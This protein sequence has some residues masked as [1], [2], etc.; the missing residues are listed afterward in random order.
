MRRFSSA[1]MLIAAS[2][3]SVSTV[4]LAQATNDVDAIEVRQRHRGG[5]DSEVGERGDRGGGF[6]QQQQQQQ[7]PVAQAQQPERVLEQNRGDQDAR[8]ERAP[9]DVLQQNAAPQTF[10]QQRSVDVERGDGGQRGFD[11]RFGGDGNRG[12]RDDVVRDADRRVD[13]RRG[14]GVQVPDHRSG[15][16]DGQ[17]F[18]HNQEYDGTRDRGYDR[19]RVWQQNHHNRVETRNRWNRDGNGSWHNDNRHDG[20]RYQ[21]YDNRYDNH[22]GGRNYGQNDNRWNRDWRRDSRYDWQRYRSSNRSFYR[23]SPYSDPYGSRY[24]YQR[25]SIGSLLNSFFYSNRYWIQDPY[26]YRLPYASSG[27]RWVRYYDDVLLVDT[28]TGYVVDVINN[29]FW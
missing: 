27:Y 29:F 18:G 2:L 19:R 11:R 8:V 5:G 14:D 12:R 21:G 25:F 4:A 7:Q 17:R 28:R 6:E 15:H 13:V 1:L 16:A 26:D 24:G 22:S 9:R 23:L 10:P 20:R 3:A